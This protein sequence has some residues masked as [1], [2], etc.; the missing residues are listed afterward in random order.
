M[1]TRSLANFPHRQVLVA[2]G[3]AGVGGIAFQLV[4]WLEVG[5]FVAGAARLAGFLSGVPV[6]AGEDGWL[7]GFAEQPLRVTAACSATDFY[8]MTTAVLGWHLAMRLRGS[9]ALVCA[10]AG[11]IPIT[12]LVNALRLIAVAQAHGWVIPR[13]PAAY[14]SFLHMLTGAAVFMPALIVLNLIF[15]Y[16]GRSSD[17]SRA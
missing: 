11:A 16:H 2:L 3:A 4:P 12:L 1:M 10:A 7:L 6:A 15:E 14:E 5:V 9:L 8:L 17:A 13:L